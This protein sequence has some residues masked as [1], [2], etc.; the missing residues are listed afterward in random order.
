MPRQ[1]EKTDVLQEFGADSTA[2]CALVVAQ[3]WVGLGDSYWRDKPMDAYARTLKSI[4]ASDQRYAVPPYQRPYVW[5]RVDQWAP[6]WTD[7]CD[8]ARRLARA[9]SEALRNG[10]DGSSAD[11]SVSPHFL[12]AIV[13]QVMGTGAGNLPEYAVVDGQQRLT[14]IQL[15]LRGL[16]DALP[17]AERAELRV[18]RRKLLKMIR[19]DEEIAVEEGSQLKLWPRRAERAHFMAAMRDTEGE[20]SRFQSAREFFAESA[21]Q[22]LEDPSSPIDPEAEDVFEGRVKLLAATMSDLMKIVVISLDGVDDAQM[23]FEVLNARNMPLSAADLVKNLLFMEVERHQVREIERLYETYWRPFDQQADWW[24]ERVGVGH[25]QR[26]R[27]DRFM[28]DF[29]T[30]RQ[31]VVINI[32]RLYGEFREWLMQSGLNVEEVLSLLREYAKAYRRIQLIETDG[33]SRAEVTSLRNI[34]VLQ[35]ITAD[36]LL[37]WLMT[38]TEDEL[39]PADRARA[40]GVIEAFLVRRMAIKSDTRGYGNVFAEVIRRVRSADGPIV[41]RVVRA[42]SPGPNGC[43]WPTDAEVQERFLTARAYGPGGINQHR[44]CLLLGAADQRMIE[45]SHKTERVEVPY[46]KLTIEHV[47]PQKWRDNWPLPA[48]G[49]EP[50]EVAALK[51]DAAVQRIGNL[52]LLTA[53]LNPSVSN[54]PWAAK[55]ETIKTHTLLQINRQLVDSKAWTEA[56]IDRRSVELAKLVAEV[57][58]LPDGA[59]ASE[60]PVGAT[61]DEE[62]LDEIHGR[63][64]EEGEPIDGH[65][66]TLVAR[67]S[68]ARILESAGI[69]EGADGGA[70]RTILEELVARG[71]V[72]IASES[73]LRVVGR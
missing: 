55:R 14:T 62:E 11:G 63:L 45:R 34:H 16:L 35:V 22:W 57:W 32:G 8:A 6:M 66:E 24:A 42:L 41:E 12:G 53:S 19:N 25:A 59:R 40:I 46:N 10:K 21:R 4:L 7:I 26:E 3:R 33:L 54:G 5:N 72:E 18:E 56:D 65:G 31:G 49:S 39:S 52:T 73:H 51:R 68:L 71:W 58:P 48:T 44:L 36:P 47:M 9:R 67:A 70:E 64:A 60:Q 43:G 1:G 30:A 61:L 38:R 17:G 29:L 15:V 50:D 27:L 37:L 13:T 69:V 28:S 2:I 20:P 23:I